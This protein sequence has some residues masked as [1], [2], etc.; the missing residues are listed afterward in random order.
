MFQA[1][2]LTQ[3]SWQSVLLSRSRFQPCMDNETQAE[4]AVTAEQLG[5]HRKQVAPTSPTMAASSSWPAGAG[6]RT[7]V[8]LAIISALYPSVGWRPALRPP[9]P[10]SRACRRASGLAAAW[11]CMPAQVQVTRSR[12]YRPWSRQGPR[13]VPSVPD[14]GLDHREAASHVEPLRLPPVVASA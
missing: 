2:V 7:R 13:S 5:R 9:R 3:P 1:A 6:G 4:F 12:W 11:A 8:R 10:S 14:G